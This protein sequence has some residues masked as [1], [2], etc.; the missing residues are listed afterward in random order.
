MLIIEIIQLLN[1]V[2]ITKI[3][4]L[5][6]R[7]YV[8]IARVLAILCMPLWCSFLFGFQSFDFERT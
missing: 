4:V 5:L 7:A 6:P 1:N 2:I 3:I 8:T